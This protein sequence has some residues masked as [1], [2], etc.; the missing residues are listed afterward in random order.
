MMKILTAV[1]AATTGIDCRWIGSSVVPRYRYVCCHDSII[2]PECRYVCCLG[3]INC[4]SNITI[5]TRI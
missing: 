1:F 3:S 4:N 5:T 2:C